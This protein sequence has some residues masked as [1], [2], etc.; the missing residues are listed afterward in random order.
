MQKA[1]KIS[2]DIVRLEIEYY[3]KTGDPVIVTQTEFKRNHIEERLQAFT[4]LVDYW[5]A[6]DMEAYRAKQL[7]E[8]T[9]E[10]ERYAKLKQAIDGAIDGTVIIK[11]D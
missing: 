11:E 3:T 4:E 10:K 9:R 6:A 8:S 5:N 2:E 7:E 1:T